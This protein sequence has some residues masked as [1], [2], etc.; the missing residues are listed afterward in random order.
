[1]RSERGTQT[2]VFC[3]VI[4]WDWGDAVPWLALIIALVA[5][6]AFVAGRLD[7]RRTLASH[8]YVVLSKSTANDDPP[9]KPRSTSA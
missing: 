4:G 3:P 8:V 6:V 7:D 9:E 1:M 5:A 2:V